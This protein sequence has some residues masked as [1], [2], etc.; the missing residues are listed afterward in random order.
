MLTE[1]NTIDDRLRVMSPE[2]LLDVVCSINRN[3]VSSIRG[4][5]SLAVFGSGAPLDLTLALFQVLMAFAEHKTPRQAFHAL[6]VDIELDD[7]AGIIGNFVERGLLKREEPIETEHSL[8]RLL[9]PSVFGDPGLVGR[10]SGWMREGK[11]I[12]IP[13]ALPADFAEKVHR[14]L[15]CSSHWRISEGGHDFFH[16][17]NSTIE[18]LDAQS[19]ALAECSRLFKNEDTRRFM[20]ELSG[21][22]CAGEAHVAAAWYRPGEYALPHDDSTARETRAVAYVWYLT[23]DWRQEWGGALFWCPTGQYVRPG[24][25]VLVAFTVMPSNIHLV[26]P[27]APTAM[28]KRLTINGFWRHA[29]QGSPQTSISPEARISPRAY[30]P[31]VSEETE[32]LPINVL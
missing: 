30:G 14:E 4:A 18:Q 15:D 9:S 27:V 28:S 16:Y 31:P 19:A 8:R 1:L 11:A 26:C 32:R 10:I 23:K 17:R 13:D 24:F 6:D 29:E 3:L 20:A 2:S 7:F 21:Q 12:V 25:N 5:D 22:N